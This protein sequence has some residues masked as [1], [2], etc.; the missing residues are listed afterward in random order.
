MTEDELV[1]AVA[2]AA[3]ASS[4]EG[5]ADEL[6]RLIAERQPIANRT[7]DIALVVLRVE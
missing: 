5:V 1:S 7:D 4:A 2:S 3:R 6:R